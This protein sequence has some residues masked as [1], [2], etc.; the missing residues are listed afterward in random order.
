LLGERVEAER[1]LREAL[2][3]MTRI[4][5]IFNLTMMKVDPDFNSL[6]DD[7]EFKALLAPKG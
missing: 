7:P 3:R 2:A 5:G 6:R 4:N 1:T